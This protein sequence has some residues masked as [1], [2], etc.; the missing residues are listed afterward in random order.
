MNATFHSMCLKP[1]I[2]ISIV[3]IMHVVLVQYIV[4]AFIE[5]FK[6]KENHTSSCLHANFDLVDVSADLYIHVTHY[7]GLMDYN[8]TTYLSVFLVFGKTT[9]KQRE[10]F[11]SAFVCARIFNFQRRRYFVTFTSNVVL[12]NV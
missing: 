6:V 3:S 5:V 8:H 2:N 9:S 11:Q 7:I 4:E 12:Q 1:K 10:R